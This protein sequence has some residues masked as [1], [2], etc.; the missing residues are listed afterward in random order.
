M[1]SSASLP[2]ERPA[3]EANKQANDQV[4]QS[5]IPN[6]V[7]G[8]KQSIRSRKGMWMWIKELWKSVINLLTKQSWNH[9]AAQYKIASVEYL[10]LVC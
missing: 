1:G 9:I 6:S 4:K 3:V 10:Q 2:V 7:A 8:S 5:S